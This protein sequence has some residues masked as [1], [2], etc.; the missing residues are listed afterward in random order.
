MRE[1]GGETDKFEAQIAEMS[2]KSHAHEKAQLAKVGLS[3]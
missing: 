3:H 2:R 1:G